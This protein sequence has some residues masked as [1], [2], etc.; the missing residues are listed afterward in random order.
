M[1]IISY[2]FSVEENG[3]TKR[4]QCVL[5]RFPAGRQKAGDSSTTHERIIQVEHHDGIFTPEQDNDK[6][7][8]EPMHSYVAFH[9]DPA[10]TGVKGLIGMHMF[11]ICLVVVLLWCEN[12]IILCVEA[13]FVLCNKVRYPL[14]IQTNVSRFLL[15]VRVPSLPPPLMVITL[16][17]RNGLL[18]WCP[19]LDRL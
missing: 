17:V 18:A 3:I 16:T 11:N 7:N 8:V 9:T 10:T 19:C 14:S 1:L 6:T 2:H 12:T 5:I 4:W 15:S 13:V